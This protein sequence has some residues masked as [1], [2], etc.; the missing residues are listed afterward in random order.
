MSSFVH[1]YSI[2]Y[3][4]CKPL[5]TWLQKLGAMNRRYLYSI[6]GLA[7]NSKLQNLV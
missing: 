3:G 4:A 2:D 1:S 7:P 5:D 6:R